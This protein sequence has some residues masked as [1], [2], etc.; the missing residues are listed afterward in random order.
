M[1]PVTPG[2]KIPE[3][4]PEPEFRLEFLWNFEPRMPCPCCTAAD[5]N[6][7]NFRESKARTKGKE[8]QNTLYTAPHKY[9]VV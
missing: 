4:G 1:I 8:Y 9:R 7:G 5:Q 6:F 2:P 3:N